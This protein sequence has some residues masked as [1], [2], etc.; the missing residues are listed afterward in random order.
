MLCKE[1]ASKQPSE[2][3]V[4]MLLVCNVLNKDAY[5]I[6]HFM[7]STSLVRSTIDYSKHVSGYSIWYIFIGTTL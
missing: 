1:L 4:R 7:C 2:K 3:C 5:H 6:L